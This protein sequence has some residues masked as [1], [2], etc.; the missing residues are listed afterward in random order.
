MAAVLCLIF[1]PIIFGALFLVGSMG[2]LTFGTL[3]AGAMF[4]VLSGGV[5]YGAMRLVMGMEPE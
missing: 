1:L 3:C 4:L 2:S 5:V